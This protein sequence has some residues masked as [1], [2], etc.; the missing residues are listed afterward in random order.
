MAHLP[1]LLGKLDDLARYK[2][3]PSFTPLHFFFLFFLSSIAARWIC[4]SLMRGLD[5]DLKVSVN[6]P[7]DSSSAVT[8]ARDLFGVRSTMTSGSKGRAAF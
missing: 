8:V 5:V 7:P 6:T 1:L 4:S 2:S 3:L